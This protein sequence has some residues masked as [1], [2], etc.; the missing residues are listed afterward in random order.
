MKMYGKLKSLLIFGILMTLNSNN[1]YL[2]DYQVTPSSSDNSGMNKPVSVE[3]LKINF[4]T[5]ILILLIHSTD[6]L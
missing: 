4:H 1:R 5:L 3:V 2:P 6:T